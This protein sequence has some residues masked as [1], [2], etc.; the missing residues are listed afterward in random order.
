MDKRFEDYLDDIENEKAQIVESSNAVRY[1]SGVEFLL[2]AEDFLQLKKDLRERDLKAKRDALKKRLEKV[3]RLFEK[4]NDE[5]LDLEVAGTPVTAGPVY[6]RVCKW[7]IEKEE[8]EADLEFFDLEH[9]PTR[10]PD[11]D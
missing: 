3:T 7:E 6:D 5:L 8:A 2:T 9:K 11:F 10:A 4:A 1:P